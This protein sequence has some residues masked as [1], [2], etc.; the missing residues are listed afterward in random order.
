MS[1]ALLAGHPPI[2]TFPIIGAPNAA[3]VARRMVLHCMEFHVEPRPDDEW[4]FTVK[5]EEETVAAPL[6]RCWQYFGPD[7]TKQIISYDAADPRSREQYGL[8]CDQPI[9][10]KGKHN[11]NQSATWERVRDL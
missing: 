9:D 11:G 3:T 8:W 6:V 5:L 2:T 10:H 7:T 4:W 1:G